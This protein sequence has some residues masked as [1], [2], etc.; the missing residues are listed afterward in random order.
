MAEKKTSTETPIETLK[1]LIKPELFKSFED[2][3]ET[4]NDREKKGLKLLA[5][6]YKHKG[7]KKFRAE[8]PSVLLSA[9]HKQETLEYFLPPA[10][11]L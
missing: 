11:S 7:M 3:Y 5:A 4:A 9:L 1:K 10:F 2:W 8:P 6:I